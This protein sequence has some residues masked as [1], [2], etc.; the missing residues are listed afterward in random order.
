MFFPKAMTEI[1]LIVPAKDLLAVTKVS[2]IHAMPKMETTAI[3]PAM[4]TLEWA[5]SE[6][7]T[8]VSSLNLIPES[9]GSEIIALCAT[10]C[11]MLE[12]VDEQGLGSCAIY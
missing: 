7:F 2:L 11:G 8:L 5:M 4:K 12:L 10:H 6:A 1:E 3:M 9:A